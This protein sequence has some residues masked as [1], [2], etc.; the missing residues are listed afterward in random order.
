M[1]K[2][3][4]TKKVTKK[5]APKTSAKTRSQ[6]QSHAV[7]ASSTSSD[8]VQ[9]RLK[10]LKIRR[11][12]II[13]V[14]IMFALGALLYYGRGIFVAA[15]V[16]GQPIS[17]VSIVHETEKQA[18]KRA[19]DAIIQYTLIEQEARKQNITIPD[20]EINDA[21]KKLEDESAKRGGNFDQELA[22]Q[23]VSRNDL[24]RL[25]KL[26]KM[27]GK[28]VGTD[29]K[30]T[31]KEVNDYLEKNKEMLPADQPEEQ[32]RKTV[33][34]QI[35]KDKLNEKVQTWLESLKNKAKILYFVQY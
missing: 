26:D 7:K 22:M 2:K 19:L 3:T 28:I 15:V 1:A 33:T 24:P 25:I 35:K 4:T 29:I 31:D 10:S 16:N 13:L 18:G 27:V 12:Y 17:R 14:I 30:V 6:V 20:K 32:L 8:S 11:S 9:T 23:G 21:I 5:S 34:E